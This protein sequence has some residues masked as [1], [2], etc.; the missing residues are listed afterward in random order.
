[1]L[2]TP[3]RFNSMVT[4]PPNNSHFFLIREGEVKEG[5]LG[6]YYQLS[7]RDNLFGWQVVRN[8]F[9]SPGFLVHEK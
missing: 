1:M 7:Q 2:A 9:P 6:T 3:A 8:W 4:L 5:D